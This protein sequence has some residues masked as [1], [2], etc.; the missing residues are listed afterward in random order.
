M[1]DEDFVVDISDTLERFF[2]CGGRMLKP[3]V[4]TVESL[5]TYIPPG[6]LITTDE[7]RRVLAHRHDVAVTCPF[8]TKLSLESLARTRNL[9]VP[10]WRV[11]KRNGALI[12]WF[13]GG[14]TL[15]GELLQG[16]AFDIDTELSPPRVKRFRTK[17]MTLEND[18]L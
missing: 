13:P 4:A 7:F 12:D 17:L 16:E 18:F 15:Q 11:V 8:D 6:R 14:V 2:G 1:L 5:L 3:S 10:Y 9:H